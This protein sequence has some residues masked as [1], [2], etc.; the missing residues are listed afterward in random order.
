MTAASAYE[1]NFSRA[2]A[3]VLEH[4]SARSGLSSWAVCRHDAQG[5]RTL[6]AV[7]PSGQ[8][9]AHQPIPDTL[10]ADAVQ[11][12]GAPIVLPDGT[13]F[14]ELLGYGDYLAEA[15][16]DQLAAAVRLYASLL[17]GLAASERA[18]AHDRLRPA[19]SEPTNDP[20]TGLATRQDWEQ[21]LHTEEAYCRD[22][23]ES[24]TVIVIELTGL[25]ANNEVRGHAAGD[26]ELRE[27]G[28][29]V[30]E[31]VA[32]QHFS[33]RLSGDCFAILVLGASTDE[34]VNALR[35]GFTRSG[36]TVSIGVGA[37]RQDG[38]LEEAQSQALAEIAATIQRN[39]AFQPPSIHTAAAVQP[40]PS[41]EVLMKNAEALAV[42]RALADGEINAYFQPIVDLRTGHVVAVEALARWQTPEGV[43]GPD[44]FLPLLHQAG[45]LGA[46]FDHILD[47]GLSKLVDL[48]RNSPSLRLA[49]NLEFDSKAESTLFEEVRKSLA[50]YQLPPE[51]LS[52][53]L[54]ERQTFEI[55]PAIRR[56]LTAVADLGVQ[57]MLDDFGSG[58]ASLE[59]L[60]SLPIS[61]VKLD[62]KFTSQVLHGEREGVV[63][64]AMIALAAEA[65]LAVIAEGIETQL[66]SDRLVRMGCTTGQG[67]LFAM[68]QPAAAVAAAIAA[69]LVTTF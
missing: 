60:T 64:K 58:F 55:S 34:I 35:Q 5:S 69:P 15:T 40:P 36:A 24:A 19:T 3:Q 13:P 46:L 54:S 11:R 48:R 45:L 20:L 6:A 41:A 42:A 44:R 22:F 30:R 27:A 65:G 28:S 62:R 12:V 9:R 33:A 68:P 16:R 32:G 17:G 18:L 63:V 26:A 1:S 2:A 47:D 53:E 66:Q 25:R 52:L 23:G 31:V 37:R 49:V 67:Y 43:H 10:G 38:T 57:L 50:K 56:D 8:L 61:G 4:L 51:A 7:D 21:R 29:I 14:G 59:T 39:T